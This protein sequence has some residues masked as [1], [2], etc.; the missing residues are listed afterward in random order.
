LT[1]EDGQAALTAIR[2]LA[3]KDPEAATVVGPEGDGAPPAAGE[4]ENAFGW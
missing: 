3:G 1:E 4:D 2:A